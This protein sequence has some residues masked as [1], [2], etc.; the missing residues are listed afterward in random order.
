MP[1]VQAEAFC[2]CKPCRGARTGWARTKS[3]RF[4]ANVKI[5]IEGYMAYAVSRYGGGQ[6]TP[7]GNTGPGNTR[8]PLPAKPK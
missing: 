7:S 5:F 6:P 3:I 2:I 1:G 4:D 8:P